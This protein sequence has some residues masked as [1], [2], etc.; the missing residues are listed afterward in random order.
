MAVEF[1]YGL[2]LSKRNFSHIVSEALS[3]FVKTETYTNIAPS[4]FHTEA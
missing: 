3:A 4:N 1:F 2:F